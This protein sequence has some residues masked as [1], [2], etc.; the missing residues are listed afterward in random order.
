MKCNNCAREIE[1]S[2]GQRFC[3]FC[4]SNVAS[5][6]DTNTN[7]KEPQLIPKTA[8]NLA[9]LVTAHGK[10]RKVRDYCRVCS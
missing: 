9:A 2:E 3:P 5:W 7:S 10:T 1:P 4:G 6:I 8:V